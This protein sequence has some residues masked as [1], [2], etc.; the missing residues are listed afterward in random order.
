MAFMLPFTIFSEHHGI[1]RKVLPANSQ[2][3]IQISEQMLRGLLRY[4]YCCDGSPG[5]DCGAGL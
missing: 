5:K 3:V 2:D 1:Q 4:G